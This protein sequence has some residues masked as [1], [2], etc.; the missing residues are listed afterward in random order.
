MEVNGHLYASATL[1]LGKK[2]LIPVG[3]EIGWASLPVWA[4]WQ[5]EKSLPLPGIKPQSPS[6]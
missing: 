3:D 1:S 4:W 5:T 6:L 2:P